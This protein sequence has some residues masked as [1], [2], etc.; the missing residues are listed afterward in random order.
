MTDWR[1]SNMT[2]SGRLTNIE[3]N[4][5]KTI[6]K[7]H[8]IGIRRGE[9]V[10]A[11]RSNA[12]VIYNEDTTLSGI[13]RSRMEKRRIKNVK[14]RE[15]ARLK[16]N[17]RP[18]KLQGEGIEFNSAMAFYVLDPDRP[19]PEK[20]YIIKIFRDGK[21]NFLGALYED[22][23]DFLRVMNYLIDFITRY[24]RL[25]ESMYPTPPFIEKYNNYLTTLGFTG[26]VLIGNTRYIAPIENESYSSELCKWIYSVNLG[27]GKSINLMQ[28]DAWFNTS[29]G[30]EFQAAHSVQ[31]G[32]TKYTSSHSCIWI[33][34]HTS[35][36]YRKP[37]DKPFMSAKL[38]GTGK[39][40]LNGRKNKDETIKAQKYLSDVLELK[41]FHINK[42]LDDNPSSDEEE[43]DADV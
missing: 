4:E 5:F 11:I 38:T 3:H 39:V 16:G 30:K 36:A 34:F 1:V 32:K 27:P 10:A 31:I 8:L 22:Y 13:I 21:Y 7:F 41:P 19:N 43:E 28:L 24:L 15:A 25:F 37:R 18:H 20:P 40:N 6:Y 29:E 35:E 14:M 26:K 2:V 17:K 42:V 9:Y 12:G 33:Y 23:S